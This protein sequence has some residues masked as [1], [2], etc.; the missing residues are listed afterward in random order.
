MG[1]TLTLWDA[2]LGGPGLDGYAYRADVY[3]APCGQAITREVFERFPEGVP[4]PLAQDSDELPQPVFFGESDTEQHCGDCG[5][6]L[7]GG[8]EER[9]RGGM[10]AWQLAHRAAVVWGLVAVAGAV[11][12]ALLGL[13]PL[14]LLWL[15][16]LSLACAMFEVVSR[17]MRAELERLGRIEEALSGRTPPS[18]GK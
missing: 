6:Y 9:R 1:E 13:G 4:D 10:R 8:E 5:E 7:Y 12:L 11:G 2:L 17:A 15:G 3:C 18:E 16:G 14:A